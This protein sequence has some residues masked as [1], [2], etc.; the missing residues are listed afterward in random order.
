MTKLSNALSDALDEVAKYQMFKMPDDDMVKRLV[1][2]CLIHGEKLR[3]TLDESP[4]VLSRVQLANRTVKSI[5]SRRE[6]V[7]RATK[8]QVENGARRPASPAMVPKRSA[9]RQSAA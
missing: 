8:H 6:K 5:I 2:D 3:V 7:L 9:S 4:A 1:A